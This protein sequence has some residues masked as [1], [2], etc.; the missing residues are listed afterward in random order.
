MH[1]QPFKRTD[2][3]S[4]LLRKIVSEIFSRN[5]HHRDFDQI[6]VTEVSVTPDLKRAH[7]Y[8]RLLDPT[9]RTEMMKAIQE[10]AKKIQREVGSQLKLRNTPHLVFQYDEAFDQGNRIEQIFA[11]IHSDEVE[12]NEEE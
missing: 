4:D 11:R 12:P 2:R 3:V 9:R 1:E 7:V 8:Y 5:K 10:Q 6:T